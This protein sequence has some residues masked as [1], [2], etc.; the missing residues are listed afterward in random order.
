MTEKT[1]TEAANDF[2]LEFR[3]E[4]QAIQD[5]IERSKDVP[6][7]DLTAH[8]NHTLQKINDLEKSLTKATAYIPSYDERQFF[9]Q[10]KQ[11]NQKL[12]STKAEL[13]P[14]AKFSF[15]SRK[16]KTTPTPIQR[17][18]IPSEENADLLSDAT[19]LFQDKENVV[20]TLKDTSYPENKSID[21][22]LSNIKHCV[23]ILEQEGVHIS[24]IH[25]KN[26]HH[27]VVFAG[28]IEGSVL[29]YGLTHSVLY[30]GC[31]QF[32]MHEA[33]HVDMM[34][35]V[36]SR[37]IIED[38]NEIQVGCWNTNVSYFNIHPRETDWDKSSHN[39]YDQIEDFNW[40]KKQ[41]SPNWK[42][43]NQAREKTLSDS[44]DLFRKREENVLSKR[45]EL[46][47]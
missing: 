33:H 28:Q 30:V 3:A 38:S 46:L 32:R 4:R 8:F 12:E 6:K 29:M 26:V 43:M 5:L 2:F 47:Q 10:L 17:E 24:A 13:T 23:I 39:Y 45:I 22:L 41:A 15:K 19:V 44:I 9:L 18:T 7:V 20:L 42:V 40:L 35:H 36:T 21:V 1:A 31:H 37:P 16:K 25:I 14:K 11:L 34:L 27:C